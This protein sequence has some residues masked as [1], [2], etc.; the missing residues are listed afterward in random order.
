VDPNGTVNFGS[1]NGTFYQVP[2]TYPTETV[3]TYPH[4]SASAFRT[5]PTIDA[6][7]GNVILGSD[8]AS[9]YLFKR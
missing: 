8:D 6:V 2:V 5:M 1:T 3:R 7:N 9:A 4:G